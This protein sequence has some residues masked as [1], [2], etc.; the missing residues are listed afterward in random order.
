MALR[1]PWRCHTRTLTL[2]LTLTFTPTA[3]A[4][5]GALDLCDT[6][7]WLLP[8]MTPPP[9][10]CLNIQRVQM[11]SQGTRELDVERCP[12]VCPK[13]FTYR[14]TCLPTYQPTYQPS[15]LPTYLLSE[16]TTVLL[17]TFA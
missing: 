1:Q 5:M 2:T 7:S 14:P 8:S 3:G 4:H 6:D 9:F 11:T 17:T 10:G 12:A 16:S 13:V 15:Y